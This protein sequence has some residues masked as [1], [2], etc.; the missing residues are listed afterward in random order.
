MTLVGTKGR[1]LFGRTSDGVNLPLRVDDDGAGLGRLVLSGVAS[2]SNLVSGQVVFPDAD[3]KLSG[4]SSLFWEGA[5]KNLGLGTDTPTHSID[6]SGGEFNLTHTADVSDDHALELKVDAAG[7]G[8]VKGIDIDYITGRIVA[9]DDEEAIII[10][11]DQSASVSGAVIGLEVISTEG[12]ARVHALEATALVGP[13]LQLAGSFSDMD[14][15]LVNATNRL[16]EF[17]TVGN[18]VEI[19]SADNDTVTIGNTVK[20]EELEFLLSGAASGPGIKP[21]FEFSTGA[22]TFG[23]FSPADGTNGL[24]NT[25]VIVWEDEDIPSWAVSGSEFL[26]RMTRTANS[27]TTPPIESKVQIAVTDEYEWDKDGDL[28]VRDVNV[29]GALTTDGNV[30]MN[31]G[32][33]DLGGEFIDLNITRSGTD[34]KSPIDID[35]TDTTATGTSVFFD[36]D[37]TV[38][39]GQSAF[40]HDVLL[41]QSNAGVGTAF[42]FDVQAS[43]AARGKAFDL[44]IN[45]T[46]TGSATG[47]SM[48]VDA[49]SGAALGID[50][51]ATSSAGGT[52][53][54][55][56]L[57]AGDTGSVSA[58]TIIGLEIDID[59]TVAGSTS[60]NLLLVEVGSKVA[61]NAIDI[62]GTSSGFTKG[63]NFTGTFT[64]GIDLG[65]SSIVKGGDISGSSFSLI[66][67]VISEFSADG[68]LGGN[69]DSALP[70]EK[71]VKTYVDAQVS[72]EDFWDRNSGIISPNV[73][74]DQ[75]SGANLNV[76]G[77]VSGSTL[78]STGATNVS[79]A[80]TTDGNLIVDGGNIGLTTD[81]NLMVMADDLLTLNGKL[82]LGTNTTDL[83]ITVDANSDSFTVQGAS[84]KGHLLSRYRNVSDIRSFV[85][86]TS[87][88]AATRAPTFSMISERTSAAAL[89]DNDQVGRLEW[90]AHDGTDYNNAAQIMAKVNGAVSANTVP[91]ELLFLTTETNVPAVRMSITA[92]GLVGIL[93][94][95]PRGTLDIGRA[96]LTTPA[97]I[98][99]GN[100]NTISVGGDATGLIAIEGSTTAILVL[101]DSGGT[102]D[103][104]NFALANAGGFTKMNILKDTG[105]V[106]TDNVFVVDMATGNI[107]I[108]NSAPGQILDVSGSVVVESTIKGAIFSPTGDGALTLRTGAS[109]AVFIDYGAGMSWRDVD[110]SFAIRMSL[111]SATGLLSLS[112]AAIIQD[113]L[114]VRDDLTVNSD[115][116]D[117]S[118]GSTTVPGEIRI[119]VGSSNRFMRMR[120]D[121]NTGMI[122]VDDGDD[123][124]IGQFDT[125]GDTTLT[126]YFIIGTT[127]G[128]TLTNSG[129]GHLITRTATGSSPV[130]TLGGTGVATGGDA[131][132][133][134]AIATS[135]NLAAR[136]ILELQGNAG[137]I[138]TEFA[139]NGNATIAN[140]LNVSGAFLSVGDARTNGVFNVAGTDGVTD[141]FLIANGDTVTVVGGIITDISAE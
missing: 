106:E 1:R 76:D 44:I 128:V 65:G 95:I 58:S 53:T 2:S 20:F 108:G 140:D 23:T 99:L 102:T 131:R 56:F 77:T 85:S 34:S 103:N 41:T 139:S 91:T 93:T 126:A 22:G 52:A 100:R 16:T 12:L 50:M 15:A 75:I 21:T 107:G 38:S 90:L 48:A 24:R 30:V 80:L 6:I 8:D 29:S 59:N 73:P 40:V 9:G 19:F 43:D 70:T 33:A 17:T 37:A 78:H 109:K 82:V 112:G 35:I 114:T 137:A 119:L 68:S 124:Q 5:G 88:N 129:G 25:G 32:S 79:G 104:Q 51:T 72:A 61:D 39:G 101:D 10:N 47:M 97:L 92:A 115:L 11:I 130:V 117:L 118:T 134:A 46:G 67:G 122:G 81:T 57:Q 7:F 31:L 132:T 120:M 110:D 113:T 63:I 133:I 28:R 18:D 14:S 54:G 62:Q 105:A 49:V 136:N 141:T 60:T 96:D 86:Q 45:S 116:L 69:S 36:V 55:M 121:T 4:S 74:S 89:A 83:S 125:T 66:S 27:L 111:D 138:V 84:I 3:K 26:I 13:V 135:D 94:E 123:F 127:G 87:N 42:K 64:T 98:T 71:A